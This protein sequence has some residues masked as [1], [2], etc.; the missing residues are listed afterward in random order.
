MAGYNSESA[1]GNCV[2]DNVGHD[3]DLNP[4]VG[5]FSTLYTQ[6]PDNTCDIN[7]PLPGYGGTNNWVSGQP[8]SIMSH[9]DELTRGVAMQPDLAIPPMQSPAINRIN[10]DCLTN[11]DNSAY[12][13]T[14]TS[15]TALPDHRDLKQNVVDFWHPPTSEPKSDLIHAFMLSTG[16]QTLSIATPPSRSFACASKSSST[17]ATVSSSQPSGNASSMGVTEEFSL[18]QATSKDISENGPARRRSSPV[19]F[20][21]WP[22]KDNAL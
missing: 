2:S 9:N 21:A 20:A 10:W 18:P 14:S 11:V 16:S 22:S 3:N 7:V 19:Q 12:N 6:F 1:K 13:T 4:F 17:E 15:S 8:S 5:L